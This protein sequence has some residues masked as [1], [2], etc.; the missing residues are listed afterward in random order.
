V[1]KVAFHKEF[2]TFVRA[3]ADARLGS[4]TIVLAI[5]LPVLL[6]IVGVAA[7]SAVWF[8]LKRRAQTAADAAAV[9][10][11]IQ[12][13]RGDSTNVLTS[14]KRA[15][16]QN[17]FTHGASSTT[18]TVNYP[19]TSGAYAGQPDAVEVS[20]SRTFQPLISK[21]F[22]ASN[23]T[24]HAR[25]VAEVKVVGQ[26]C[27][28]ALSATASN[29]LYFQ[30]STIVNSAG[31]VV[32]ANSNSASA[33]AMAGDAT[34]TAESV[35]SAGGFTTGNHSSQLS[36]SSPAKTNM[37]A[38]DDPYASLTK[39]SVGSC[40]SSTQY[41]IKGTET[42]GPGVYCGGIDFG[43]KA[44][45]T[46]TSGVYYI[47]GGTFEANAGATLKSSG[48]GVTIVLTNTTDSANPATIKINGGA[49]VDLKAPSSASAQFPGVLMFQDGTTE[50]GEWNKLNGGSTMLLKGAIYFPKQNI[51][52]TGDNSSTAN[53]CVILVANQLTF[54]GNSTIYNTGC[55]EA[56]IEPVQVK[57][58]RLRE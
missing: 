31:C 41:Q 2:G 40:T 43:S 49:N 21:L 57:G 8:E 50:N 23:Y 27:I 12:R 58:V 39:G 5:A 19:P 37:W 56:G 53:T 3:L 47:N 33:V 22:H 25:A 1:R 17:G 11:A 13:A 51:E 36:L 28:L 26:A 29:A 20:I 45:V 42:I 48:D 55:D 9:A 18:V 10:G 44:N 16:T 15:A 32:A 14:A 46:M 30:G 38:L 24:V 54:I 52:F 34:L 7:E 6:G 4:M 35:W